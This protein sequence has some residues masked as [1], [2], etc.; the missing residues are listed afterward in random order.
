MRTFC[1]VVH[2]SVMGQRLV[3][4]FTSVFLAQSHPV[5]MM[6]GWAHTPVQRQMSSIIVYHI[7]LL[8]HI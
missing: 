1:I 7:L 6:V 8:I 4:E 5:L 3:C 2:V